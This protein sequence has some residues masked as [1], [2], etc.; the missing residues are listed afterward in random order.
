MQNPKVFERL[1]ADEILDLI[2]PY[3]D[4]ALPVTDWARWRNEHLQP[5]T[6]RLSGTDISSERIEPTFVGRIESF[7]RDWPQ[8]LRL[9]ALSPQDAKTLQRQIPRANAQTYDHLSEAAVARLCD[10]PA[11]AYEWACLG[12]SLPPACKRNAS[13]LCCI[14]GAPSPPSPPP[15][16]PSLPP[17]LPPSLPTSAP[18]SPSPAPPRTLAVTPTIPLSR[19][20][21]QSATF[22]LATLR[23][24]APLAAFCMLVGCLTLQYLR[25]AC[26]RRW[27]RRKF[28]RLSVSGMGGTRG[29]AEGVT[30]LDEAEDEVV[31]EDSV[32]HL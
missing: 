24:K 31:G 10:A 15:L 8:L 14:A 9:L 20:S 25:L 12:Y 16:P 19:T 5:S 6:W 17:P 4:E 3:V 32:Y 11:F 27:Q 18:A 1:S 23:F 2:L 21:A 22:G 30:W 7:D 26:C 29:V 28:L 13:L